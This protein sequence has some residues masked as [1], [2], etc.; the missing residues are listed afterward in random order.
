MPAD[1]HPDLRAPLANAVR[2][3]ALGWLAVANTVGVLLAALLIWPDLGAWLGPLTYGRWMPVHLNGHLYGWCSLPIVGLLLRGYLDERQ[4]DAARHV[5]VALGA[6]SLA[7]ALGCVAWLGGNTSGKLFLDWHGWSRPVLPLAMCVLW[8]V[9]AAHAWSRRQRNARALVLARGVLL[10]AL[11]LVP[12]LFYWS[13]GRDVYPPVNPD[14]G[15]ATGASLLG[16]TLG[17]VTIFGLMPGLLGVRRTVSKLRRHIFVVALVASFG[18]YA[19]IDH[20]H[21]SHHSKGQILGLGLLLAWVPLLA[22]FLRGH[23]WSA[24]GRA[25]LHAGLGWWAVLAATGWLTFLPGLSERLKFTNGLVAHAHLAMA[26]LVSCVGMVVLQ[27]LAP[28]RPVRRGFFLW[29][30]ACAVQLAALWVVGWYEAQAGAD[31]FLSAPWTQVGYVVRLGSGAVMA[32]VAWTWLVAAWRDARDV[33]TP[34]AVV[35]PEG[36]AS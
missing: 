17:I 11:L 7:L 33:P 36:A 6:W 20:G 16:S 34:A 30:V 29:Q 4:P 3:H 35:V 12:G 13:A 26:G 25:W 5:R 22:W 18:V 23:A 9:L 24:A 27:E 8:T 19:A 15:G 31:L 32:G 10:A 21:A 2:V 28:E 1:V 14:S